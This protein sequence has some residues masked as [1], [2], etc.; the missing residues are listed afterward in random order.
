[1]S[2]QQDDELSKL[3][4][5]FNR[6]RRTEDEQETDDKAQRGKVREQVALTLR[7]V[8]LPVLQAMATEIARLGHSAEIIERL[9][10]FSDPSV[11]LH[12]TLKAK[13]HT[14]AHASTLTLDSRGGNIN[15]SIE[16]TNQS[17]RVSEPNSAVG[18]DEIDEAWVRKLCMGFVRSV[19]SAN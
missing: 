9:A 6:H 15:A 5:E 13:P 10:E 14:Y 19:L 4:D 11:A 17:G 1:M 12:L 8:A 2:T 3:F 18:M 16:V 7:N